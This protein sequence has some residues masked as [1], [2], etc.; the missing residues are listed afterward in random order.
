MNLFH[1]NCHTTSSYNAHWVNRHAIYYGLANDIINIYCY[2]DIYGD[3]D[4][5]R[6]KMQKISMN[7]QTEI[8]NFSGLLGRVN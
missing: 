2:S 8:A 6:R 5:T 3:H 4:S 1:R 7:T